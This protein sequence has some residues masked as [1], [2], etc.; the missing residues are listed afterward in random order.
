MQDNYRNICK[1]ARQTAG[2]TQERFAEA[3]DI[4]VEAVRQYESEKIM[5]SDDVVTRMVEISSQPV[6]GYWHLL[7]K[8]RVAADIL[9]EIS[10]CSLPQAVIQLICKIRDFGERHRTDDLMDIAAD[11]RI[12]DTERELFNSIVAELDSVVQAA[13]TVKYAKGE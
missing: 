2:L 11:G 8:S 9:P 7:N 6:L 10:E 1:I 4:S 5:P 12:D 13:M 3:L